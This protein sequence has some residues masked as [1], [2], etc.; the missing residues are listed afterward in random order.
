M[1]LVVGGSD[2]G[3]DKMAYSTVKEGDI[4]FNNKNAYNM[5]LR[6]ESYPTIS[7]P[8]EDIEEINVDGRSGSLI[9]RKGTYADTIIKAKLT[10]IDDNIE[11]N[12]KN[13]YK[14]LKQPEDNELYINNNSIHYIVKNVEIG[15]FQKEF[16]NIGS[17]DVTFTCK[18]F[19][20]GSTLTANNSDSTF[21]VNY[22]G[23]APAEPLITVN[24]NGNV[25]LSINGDTVKI[26]GVDTKA[27]ID[28]ENMEVT[29]KSGLSINNK[30]E[31]I[32]PMLTAGTN[33]FRVVAG[34]VSSIQVKY[35]NKY[36]C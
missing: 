20:E 12:F 7:I 21:N 27:V 13:V 29:N 9:V 30:Y 23:T 15:D 31:G 1:T 5:G 28:S 17:F 35:T 24:G 8:N 34:S 33:T 11:I 14:W 32:F 2:K 4:R 22:A 25:T 19:M 16:K 10:Y 18:P 6:L 3:D 26:Y 36:Y